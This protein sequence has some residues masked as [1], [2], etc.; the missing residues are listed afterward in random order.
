MNISL[1]QL[2]ALSSIAHFQSIT[3][4]AKALNMTQPA[5]SVQLKN[6][7]E[8]FDVPLTEIIGKKIH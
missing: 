7:Q 5:V 3:K 4:A 2:K 1:N 8:N 6:L